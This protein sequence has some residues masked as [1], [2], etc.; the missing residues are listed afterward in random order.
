MARA[1]DPPGSDVNPD[2]FPLWLPVGGPCNSRCDGCEPEPCPPLT[3]DAVRAV[4]AAARPAVVVLTGPGEPTLRRDLA[5]LVHAARQGG[6]ARVALV[7][8]GRMLA[9]PGAASTVAGLRLDA[10]AVTLL[11]PD[12]AVHDRIARVEGAFVQTLAGARNLARAGGIGWLLART[13]STLDA[14]ARS[15]LARTAG[16]VGLQALWLDGPAR[17]EPGPASLSV[18]DRAGFLRQLSRAPPPARTHEGAV[19][20]REHPG[21]G[22]VS[23]VVRTGCRNACVFCTTRLIQEHNRAPWPLE[24]LTAFHEPL[25]EARERGYRSLRLVAVEP[26]EHP[27]IVAFIDRARTL[28]YRRIEAWTSG[29]ALADQELLIQLADAGLTHVDVPL[30]GGSAVVHDRVAGAA[31]SFEETVSG[32]RAAAGRL[33]IRFHLVVVRQNLDDLAGML[34]LGRSLGLGEPASVLIPAPSLDDPEHYRA[35]AFSHPAAAAALHALGRSAREVLSSRGF[36]AQ[37]PPCVLGAEQELP[38]TAA[39]PVGIRDGKLDE[40]GA[41][42]KLRVPCSLARGCAAADRCPGHHRAYEAGLGVD[43]LA[44]RPAG[45]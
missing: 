37:L 14:P 30:L 21:E 19:P 4:V 43:A 35:F 39:Q 2:L 17:G 31:G 26:L 13:P 25:A 36:V 8:N 27:D 5:E 18:V 11:D 6:A 20:I 40:P 34:A 41:A 42:A 7:T 45:R 33:A 9:Y 32:L 29:R 3:P 10:V 16:E 15:R 1:P 38:R 28:G 12:P 24:E 44:P 22:A 23:L